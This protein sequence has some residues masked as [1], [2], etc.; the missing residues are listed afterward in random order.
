MKHRFRVWIAVVLLAAAAFGI[1]PSPA[2]AAVSPA[3][4]KTDE[5]IRYVVDN[6]RKGVARIDVSAFRFVY[7]DELKQTVADRVYYELPELFCVERLT[8][9]YT[10]ILKAVTVEYNCQPQEYSAML[11]E[12]VSAADRL[13]NGIEGNAAL[14]EAEKALLIHDRLAVHCEYDEAGLNGGEP[15]ARARDL[16]GALVNRVAVCDGYTRAYLYLLNRVGIRCSYCYSTALNHSWNVVWIGGVPYYVDVTYDDPTPDIVGRVLHENFLLSAAAFRANNHA[17]DD[18]PVL[19]AG[20]AYD[21]WFWRTSETAFVLAGGAIYYLDTP[22]GTVR[23][24]A[25]RSA[26]FTVG[27][28]W[29]SYAGCYTRLSAYGTEL[30]Y[31]VPDGVRRYETTNGKRETIFT[32]ALSG[33]DRVYGFRFEDSRLICELIDSPNGAPSVAQRRFQSYLYAPHTHSFT[34]KET[35]PDCEHDGYRTYTCACGY[36]YSE[37]TAR[38]A[39][40][41]RVTDPGKGASCRSTGLTEGCRCK[42]CGKT[43]VEQSLIP[44]LGHVLML[45]Y[46]PPGCTADGAAVCRCLRCG[47]VWEEPLSVCFHTAGWTFRDGDGG[48][49]R[50]CAICGAEIAPETDAVSFGRYDINGD[51]CVNEADAHYALQ[52]SIGMPAWPK[53]SRE[54]RAADINGDGAVTAEDARAILRLVNQFGIQNSE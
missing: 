1:L 11:A 31:S 43:L 3:A 14:G 5:I 10:D 12:C 9:V 45:R 13:L 30:Y 51:D 37:V 25:D 33:R 8:F 15:S 18:Y 22:S 34:K 41:D 32:A 20:T 36:S 7:S 16:Y 35:Q 48:Q 53:D 44:P 4:D 21:G 28:S 27:E 50:G 24:Y 26:V 49:M 29:P 38:S 40:H 6:V 52:A 47:V 54:C 2:R 23:R 42:T 17:A 46:V 19:S 39:G